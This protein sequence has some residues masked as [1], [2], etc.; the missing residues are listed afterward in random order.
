VILDISNRNKKSILYD[1]IFLIDIVD[2]IVSSKVEKLINAYGG[3][4]LYVLDTFI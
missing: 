2:K 1:K 3:V 4:S